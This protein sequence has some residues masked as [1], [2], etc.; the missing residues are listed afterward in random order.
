MLFYHNSC[1]SYKTSTRNAIKL[2]DPCL[3]QKL[4]KFL[5]TRSIS[6]GMVRSR[7][8]IG[9]PGRTFSKKP[10]EVINSSWIRPGAHAI[11]KV[12]I[13]LKVPADLLNK[14]CQRT[15]R[16]ELQAICCL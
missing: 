13:T 12:T 7:S 3:V 8:C 16:T 11:L 1:L 4:I 5:F 9:G 6:Q 2:K 10:V 14:S 15:D